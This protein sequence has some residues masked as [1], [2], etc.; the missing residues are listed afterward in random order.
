MVSTGNEEV[1]PEFAIGEIAPAPFAVA[2][3]R[4]A[5]GILP[6]LPIS[7]RCLRTISQQASE[8]AWHAEQRKNDLNEHQGAPCMQSKVVEGRPSSIVVGV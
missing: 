2:A 5:T 7:S 3:A 6:V 8:Q 4:C 1:I